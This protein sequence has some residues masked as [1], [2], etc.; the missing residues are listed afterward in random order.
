MSDE[1]WLYP[2]TIRQIMYSP[3]WSGQPRKITPTA[4]HLTVWE[5]TT[6]IMFRKV[7]ASL[8]VANITVHEFTIRR[9]LNNDSVYGRVTKRKKKNLHKEH[10]A[11][12]LYRKN[13][14]GNLISGNTCPS[15]FAQLD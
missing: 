6:V 7:K 13:N 1:F 5:N 4:R 11:V 15:S 2:P 10:A 9:T 3:L 8:A 12:R 14:Q